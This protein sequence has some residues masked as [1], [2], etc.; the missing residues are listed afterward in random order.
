MEKLNNLLQLTSYFMRLL[1]SR[2]A[3]ILAQ[4]THKVSR[5]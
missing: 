3:P 5:R 1:R 2:C 4:N